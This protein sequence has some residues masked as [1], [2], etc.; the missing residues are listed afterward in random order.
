[1]NN[2]EKKYPIYELEALSMKAALQKF[3]FYILGYKVIVRSDNQ[4][5]LYLL[6][7]KECHGRVTKYM[8][9]IMEFNPTFEYI[10]GTDNFAADFMSRN[11][12]SL[13]TF[14][15]DANLITKNILKKEQ[16]QDVEIQN[17]FK[18]FNNKY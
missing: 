14:N 7:S 3:R 16:D 17:D 9:T 18:K 12:Q 5:A 1:M 11:V 10:R 4:P 13:N 8:A 2:A 6:R 15:I